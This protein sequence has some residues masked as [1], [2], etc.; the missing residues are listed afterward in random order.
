MMTTL[1]FPFDP[2]TTARIRETGKTLRVLGR[3]KA[4][5][6]GFRALSDFARRQKV[7][8]EKVDP[9]A[10]GDETLGD[11]DYAPA[12]EALAINW[13]RR[14]LYVSRQHL[15]DPAA[16]GGMVHELGHLVATRQPP[17]NAWETDFLGWEWLVA[18]KLGLRKAW[19]LWM[20]DYVME[21]GDTYRYMTPAQ[22]YRALRSAVRRG[23]EVGNIDR[24]GNPTRI[25]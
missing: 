1:L 7:M 10:I 9:D 12:S 18:R 5:T 13:K 25:R 11:I 24:R 3:S 21:H 6:S 19:G 4:M 14:Y 22:R 20:L 2:A 16:L 23:Q 8:V 17:G 15:A